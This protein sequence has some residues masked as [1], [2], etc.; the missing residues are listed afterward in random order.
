MHAVTAGAELSRRNFILGLINGGLFILLTA[1]MD[2]DTVVT[3]FAWQLTGGNALLIGILVSVIN[4][5]WFWPPLFLSPILATQPR[6]IPWYWVSVITRLV[7]LF[8][9]A[10]VAWTIDRFSMGGGFALFALMFLVY[11]VGGGVSLIPFMSIVSDTIPPQWRGKFFGA[12]Y[13]TGGLAAFAAGFG[14][15]AVLSDQGPYHFPQNYAVLFTL[16]AILAVPSLI[17]FCFVEEVPRPLQR[18]RLPLMVEWRRGLRVLRRD[19]NFRRL[20]VARSTATL[21]LGLSLPFIVPYALSQ[22]GS[23]AAAVGL[24]MSCKVLTYALSNVFWSRVSDQGGNRRLLLLSALMGLG[25]LW[26]LLGVR[27]LPETHL[28]TVAGLSLSWRV[29]FL[30]VIFAA[31]GFSNAGQE[32]GY[33]NFLLELIP[34]RKR[35]TYLSVFYLVWLPMCWVP[36]LGALLIGSG[37]RFML[38]FVLAALLSVMLVRFTLRLRE[39]RDLE[40]SAVQTSAWR[41]VRR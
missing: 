23:P 22:L 38:G 24:F 1:V 12:R 15:K 21:M 4:T 29:A 31:F 13:L 11:T 27:L 10:A 33:T 17:A 26:M 19:R 16:A 9:M 34:E 3:G 35:P 5:G 36:F 30:C 25:A 28:T 41:R 6:L 39:V 40:V 8:A 7:G 20:V 37:H 14:V 32:I 18:R 2:T